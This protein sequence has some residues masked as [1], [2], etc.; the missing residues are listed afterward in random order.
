MPVVQKLY[1][2]CKESFSATGP[3]SEEALENVRAILDQMKPSNVGLEQE[4]QLARQWKG[5]INGTNGRKGRNG[6]LQYPPP[7]KY[8]H[9]HECDRFSIGIFCMPPSSIIPLHNHPGMIVLSKLLYGSLLVKSYDWLDLPGHNDPSQARP[10]RLVRDCEMTAPCGTTVLYPSSGGN[11]HCFKAITPCALF[12]VLSPPYSSEDG[13][14]CSYFRRTLKRELPEG[15]EE[16]CGIEPSEIA[17]LEETQP[18]ENVVVRR[19][20]YK[21]PTIRR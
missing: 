10:A 16:L 11:I 14:H 20:L 15:T 2:A 8:L 13:R 7:I 6:S 18:P 5:S 12:D 4:A 1:D 9:L 3:V 17:W 21:G 19:G